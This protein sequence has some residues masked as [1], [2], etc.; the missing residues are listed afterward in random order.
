M[1]ESHPL[2]QQVSP[3]RL[4]PLALLVARLLE[5]EAASHQ[6]QL[7]SPEQMLDVAHCRSHRLSLD[8]LLEEVEPLEPVV[9]HVADAELEKLP[10]STGTIAASL[11]AQIS[12]LCSSAS[13]HLPAAS[14]PARRSAS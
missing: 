7:L 14:G 5:E 2:P 10:E 12:S 11:D 8:A 3:H 1:C 13:F 6:P 9:A 4:L